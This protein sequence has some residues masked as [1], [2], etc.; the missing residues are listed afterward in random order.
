MKLR[1]LVIEDEWPAREYLVELLEESGVAEV[2]GAVGTIA[3]GKQALAGLVLDVAFVDIRLAGSGD[4]SGLDLV[5]S[6]AGGPGAP[7]FVLATA[8]KE[9]AAEAYALDVVDYLL[10]PFTAERVE[11]C[12]QR[13]RARRPVPASSTGAP[14]R[15]VARQGKKLVFLEPSE[16]WAFEARD[17]L[18]SVHT[19]HGVFDVDLS[20]AVIEQSFGSALF[21][22]HRNWLVNPAFIKELEREGRE[23]RIF[24]GIGLGPQQQGVR[25]PV[26]RERVQDVRDL[27]FA[28]ATGTRQTT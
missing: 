13:L 7:M 19:P 10:K 20:L 28:G 8:F 3:E 23:T 2:V 11:Q 14:R 4:V 6:L 24:V 21:R 26:G 5:R 27:L 16:V 25:V 12:L 22:V 18:T 1:A 17:R 9:H 15:I